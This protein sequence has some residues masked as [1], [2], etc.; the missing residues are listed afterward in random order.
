MQRGD[1]KRTISKNAH[2]VA[3]LDLRWRGR[4]ETQTDL[5]LHLLQICHATLPP[6]LGLL[7]GRQ[8]HGLRRRGLA[9]LRR[10]QGDRV[11]DV[12][13]DDALRPADLEDLRVVDVVVVLAVDQALVPPLDLR[14][15]LDEVLLLHVRV[16]VDAG[17]ARLLGD[18]LPH[19]VERGLPAERV[20]LRDVL[21]LLVEDELPRFPA[22][23]AA[24]RRL[25]GVALVEVG[26]A[27]A[28]A[29]ARDRPWPA[30]ICLLLCVL[31]LIA[32][33]SSRGAGGGRGWLP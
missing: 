5:G 9:I 13:R 20:G 2:Q 31:C 26:V 33:A 19:G 17:L 29:D 14:R 27:P 15:L 21:A 25:R 7:P 22:L 18:A 8:E 16:V 10:L 28:I 23:A 3:L 6:E 32:A 4:D 24:A 12:F 11:L 30:L 1:F